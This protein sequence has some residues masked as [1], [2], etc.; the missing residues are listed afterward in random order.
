V[1]LRADSEDNVRIFASLRRLVDYVSAH[2]T[3]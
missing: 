2:R 1:Q 3:K